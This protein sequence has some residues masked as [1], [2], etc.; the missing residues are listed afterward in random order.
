[1]RRF[2]VITCV[3]LLVASMAAWGQQTTGQF[4]GMIT[5]SSGAV[6]AGAEV[7]AKNAETGFSRSTESNSS[8]NYQLAELPPGRYSITAGAKGFSKTVRDN[9]VIAVGQQ[10]TANFAL[11]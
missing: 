3:L 1:M 2:Y 5:D 6:V 10:L 8:G 7:I 4:T 9:V 11:R